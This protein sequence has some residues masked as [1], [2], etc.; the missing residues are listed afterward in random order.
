MNQKIWALF[1][2]RRILLKN[3]K[4]LEISEFCKKRSLTAYLGVDKN[5]FYEIVFIRDAKSR[6]LL[7]EAAQIN[8]IC[9]KF[10]QKFQTVI[11]KRVIFYN[12]QICSKS[13]DTLRQNGWRCYDFV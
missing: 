12:S 2:E 9:A 4:I 3:L 11:K 8:E 10:E 6:L 1:E 7:K 13:L 5:S